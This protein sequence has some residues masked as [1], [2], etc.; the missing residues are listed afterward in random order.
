MY[1][2]DQ[3]DQQIIDERVKQYRGQTERFLKGELSEAEFLPLRLQNG[4]YV[5]RLAPMLRIAVPYGLMSSKQLR[6]LAAIS[7][8]YDK[9]YAHISTRQNV[10][11][12]WPELADTPDILAELASVQMHAVQTSGN[13]IRSTTSDQFAGVAADELIDPRPYCEI[14]R[15]WSTF[16][17]EFAY[18]PRKFKIAVCGSAADRAAIHVHD[19]GIE[20]VHNEKAEIGYKVIVGGGLGRTPVIGQVVNEFL[21]E[22]HLL[23]YLDAILRV[24]NQLGRRDNKYKARIKILVKAMGVDA[25]REKVDAEWAFLKDGPTT[26]SDNEIDRVKAHFTDPDYQIIDDNDAE[27]ALQAQAHAEP[28]FA[29]WLQ[30]NTHAHK[31]AGYQAVTLSLK[32]AGVA[33]GDITDSQ[34]DAVADLADR[35]SFGELRS[36]HQQNLIL[37]DVK[38]SDLFA[39]WQ[40]LQPLGLAKANIG[41]LTDMICC[42]GG[43]YCA[44]ANAKSI[45][46][47]EA[48]TRKFNDL[49]YLYDLGQIE[50]NISGCMNACGHHHVGHIGILGVD[51]KGEEF[52]QISLGGNQDK[53]TSL[54]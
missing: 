45:P 54:G 50:L 14:I 9:G 35:F 42:P 39:L 13:C 7:R 16:H 29:A 3:Y 47:S 2:Y 49:D 27:L 24:Y 38:K 21:P 48:I 28:A 10:Q 32:V 44:L 20:L 22:Q 34:M 26:L 18:L 19:I 40:Q 5:Q 23:S 25:F 30:H 11:L 31:Q 12:N 37:A 8:D 52:F 53:D 15:Q 36:S 46:V 17:P 41:T 51:K 33:P 4:L 1:Q 43:D 6:K